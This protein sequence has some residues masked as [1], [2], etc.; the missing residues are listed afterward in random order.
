MNKRL[1]YYGFTPYNPPE[2]LMTEK[3]Y[4]ERVDALGEGRNQTFATLEFMNKLEDL[5]NDLYDMIVYDQSVI[6]VWGTEYYLSNDGDDNNDGLTPETA[7]KTLKKA[8]EF[9]FEQGDGLY[10]RRGD[11]WRGNLHLQSG[12]T[13]QPYGEGEKPKIYY[14]YNGKTDAE[15]VKT[16]MENVWVFDK[17]LDTRDI[18]LIVFDGGK[19]YAKKK[20]QKSDLKQDLDFFYSGFKTF[21]DEEKNEFKAYLYCSQ[22]NPAEVFEEIEL[23]RQGSTIPIHNFQHDILVHNLDIRYGQDYFLCDSSKN[24]ELTYCI[25]AFM[26]G[27]YGGEAINNGCYGFGGG[28]GAWGRCDNMKYD[29]CFFTMHYDCAVTAQ[30]SRNPNKEKPNWWEVHP[31]HFKDFSV[32][33]CLIE[34]S[35]YGVEFFYTQYQDSDVLGQPMN[36]GVYFGYNIC[37]KCEQGFGEKHGAAKFIRM[38]NHENYCVNTVFEKNVFDRSGQVAIEISCYEGDQRR[39]QPS[40]E[41]M[42]EMRGN[43]YVDPKDKK[44][45]IVN[46][47]YYDFNKH[48][49]KTL[50]KLGLEKDSVYVYYLTDDVGGELL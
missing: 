30:F 43:I 24:I 28:G 9:K 15:W 31:V 37:R 5:R 38:G 35:E 23:S 20:M 22:G 16:D 7:W 12:V 21:K 50:E 48:S 2:K 3:E 19:Q 32:N 8:S 1:D 18:G 39:N 26:G 6:K 45:A 34:Y 17:V 47:I 33:D 25:L 11:L 46:G 4:R 44:Y 41:H 49:Q 36:D 10:L 42:P 13:Y 29:H 14:S 40:Y 27:H